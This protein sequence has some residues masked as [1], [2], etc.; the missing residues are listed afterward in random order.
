MGFTAGGLSTLLWLRS[1]RQKRSGKRPEWILPNMLAPFFIESGGTHSDYPD[2]IW[3]YLNSAFPGGTLESS[4]KEQLLAEWLAAGRI[5]LDST[6]KSKQKIALLTSTNAADKNLHLDS[7]G[8]RGAM[9]ADVR[10]RVS[11]MNRDLRE[12]M[13]GLRP[14]QR[15][16]K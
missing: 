8:E 5:S 7:L 4:R 9:L 3:T 13:Q 11:L 10:N 15:P 12:L 14:S 1:Y 2:D 16:G 6:H